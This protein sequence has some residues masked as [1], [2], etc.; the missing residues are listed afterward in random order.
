VF[1][2][3]SETDFLVNTSMNLSEI[4]LRIVEF[5]CYDLLLVEGADDPNIPK[6]QMGA[7]K[8]RKNTIIS[9][10]NNFFEL[11]KI[12]KKELKMK[13]SSQHLFV[14]VNGK[15][16]SLTKFPEQIFTNTIVGMVRSLKGV[17][18]INEVTIQLRQ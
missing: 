11:L 18:N 16:I 10:E 9:Y 6:I 2:S 17:Q 14:R 1:S 7:G 12:I 3:S 8:K 4:I 5:G 13:Q 15:N